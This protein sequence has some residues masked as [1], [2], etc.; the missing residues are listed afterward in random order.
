MMARVGF[1]LWVGLSIGACGGRQPLEC[2]TIAPAK[3]SFEEERLLENYDVSADSPEA[4]VTAAEKA[5]PFEDPTGVGGLGLTESRWCTSWSLSVVDGECRVTAFQLLHRVRITLPR[6][7]RPAT[8]RSEWIEWD[9]SAGAKLTAHEEGHYAIADKAARAAYEQALGITQAAT[10]DELRARMHSLLSEQQKLMNKKQVEYDEA[11][12]H[13][14][15]E[16]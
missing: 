11:S 13:G 7:K 8:A 14:T 12:Q 10:C 4:Y 6:W 1:T 3:S 5:R 9:K 2:K 16:P 15:V